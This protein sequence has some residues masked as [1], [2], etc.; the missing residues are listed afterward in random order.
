MADYN[1]S[2]ALGINPQDSNQSLNTL[3]KIMQLGSTG[4]GIQQQKQ[5]LV[6]QQ[7]ENITKA[8]TAAQSQIETQRQ[9]GLQTFFQNWDPSEHD[10]ADGTTDMESARKSDAYKNS[11]LAKPDI[12]LK[13]A[14]I[15]QAQ[16]Q[17]KQSLTSL[18]GANLEQF[19]KIAQSLSADEDVKADKTDPI[20][21]VNA[22]RAKVDSALQNFSKLGPDAAR[23]ASIYAPVT[24]HAPPGK[25]LTGITSIAA[26]AQDIAGQQAQTNPA[27]ITTNAG[28]VNRDKATGALSQPPGGATGS[29]INPSIA[30]GFEL[31]EDPITH[32]KYLWNRQTGETKPFGTG[33]P[34]GGGGP[35]AAPNLPPAAPPQRQVGEAAAQEAQ[36]NTNF[37]THQANVKAASAANQ[38]LDQIKNVS[39]LLDQGV[40]TGQGAQAMSQAEQA[41]SN[42]P[43]LSGLAGADSQAAKFDLLNKFLERIGADYGSLNGSPAKTDAG[44]ESLR[45]QIGSTG[46]NPQALRDV[47]KYTAA[48]Y[49]AAKSKDTAEQNFL[50][51]KGNGILNQDQFEKQWRNSY[52]P[53]VFQL[54]N[55]PKAVSKAA[56]EKMEPA[57]RATFLKK[58]AELKAMGAAPQ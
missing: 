20:T 57:D 9:Q 27:A 48:Q 5:A 8:S 33:A 40:K 43:G 47:M 44:A 50:A 14:Q 24:Q 17:N 6:G 18:N 11:G 4:L 35:P 46:Y 34:V 30:P 56:L 23:V 32:N 25:L 39:T 42:I 29:A 15:K 55:E 28:V 7:S 45:S 31:T 12:D 1:A 58:Y 52:D 13:L 49:Q 41:L 38:Q 3:S 10:G 36:V 21:G 37:Q 53:R 54:A 51:Q 19:G 16:L 2:V 22:G 26:Q